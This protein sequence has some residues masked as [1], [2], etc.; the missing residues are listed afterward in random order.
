MPAAET[1]VRDVLRVLHVV[2]PTTEGAAQLV[3]DLASAQV[4]VGWEAHVASPGNSWL[5]GQ[6]LR[7]GA[8]HHDW[9]AQRSPLGGLRTESASLAKTLA[10]VRPDVV[11]LHSSK[12]GLV[13]RLVVKG[14]LPTLFQPHAWSFLH[15]SA[16]IR[17]G[18][19]AWERAAARWTHLVVCGSAEEE[20]L[21]RAS[22][23]RAPTVQVPNAV[24]T[25]R[26]RS[27]G[28][29][30]NGCRARL[31]LGDTPLV[32]CVGR[33]VVQKGQ[34]VLLRAWPA[35]TA[36][37]PEASLVLVGDGSQ[38]RELEALATGGVRFVGAQ[39]PIDWFGAADVVVQPSR[40]ETL[41]L[42]VLEAMASSRS[43]VVTDL[44]SM[45]Q[46]LGVSDGAVVPLDDPAALA[47]AVVQRLTDP[48]LRDAEGLRNRLRVERE[49][50]LEAWGRRL[51]LISEELVRGAGP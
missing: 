6:V 19:L 23:V 47:S 34:D 50:G 36:A 48:V 15:G 44:P 30:R 27:V 21:T 22:G 41:S 26:Y 18:A 40:W 17:R 13:G 7:A 14:R 33:L 24:D 31:G 45:R 28:Q 25:D 38:R 51:M 12:A 49:F 29:A 46:A 1:E 9:P 20:E 39:Q 35:V 5:S 42:S 10:R 3:A 4:R 8:E 16:P 2:Q 32:V 43:V 11:H 37:V